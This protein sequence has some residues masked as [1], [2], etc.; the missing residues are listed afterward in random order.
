MNAIVDVARFDQTS[1]LFFTF[2]SKGV[3]DAD[4][5]VTGFTVHEALNEL[6]VIEL[7]LASR[8]ADIDLTKLMD[9]DGVLTVHDRYSEAKRY[10]H[11]IVE[12]AEKGDTGDRFTSYHLT[13]MPTLCRG[14]YITDFRYFQN[15]SVIDIA[16]KVLQEMKIDYQFSCRD[17]YPT[18]EYLCQHRESNL[19]FLDRIL[20]E[21]GIGYHFV[22]AKDGHKMVLFDRSQGSDDCP[23]ATSLEYNPMPSGVVKGSFLSQL[24]WRERMMPTKVTLKE[25]YYKNPQ[26]KFLAPKTAQ[27]MRGLTRDLEVYEYP[28]RHKDDDV[29]K[30][31][32]AHRLD[33]LRS[34]ASCGEA[35]GRCQHLTAGYRFELK[36]HA[37]AAMNRKYFIVSVFHQGTQPT[38][39]EEDAGNGGGTFLTS[40]L[41][42]VKSDDP[43]RPAPRPRALVDGPIMGIITGPAGEEIYC[44]A[45]GRVRAQP[46]YDRLGKFDDKSSCWIRVSQNWAG[47]M[48]GHIAVPRVGQHVIIDYI[49]GDP[50]QPIIVGR[51][52]NANN[53][54]PNKLPDF[55]T[56]MI[57]QSKTHKGEGEN[58]VRLEDEKDQ[59]EFFLQA[60][61]YLN[62]HVKDNETHETKGNRHKRVDGNHSESIGGN[63]DSEV[64]GDHREKITGSHSTSIE[65]SRISKIA[66]SDIIKIIGDKITHI[67][68][69]RFEYIEENLRIQAKGRQHLEVGTTM[70]VNAGDS[71]VIQAGAS[72]SLNVGGNFVKIDGSGVQIEG[73]LIRLNCGGSPAKGTPVAPQD[74]LEPRP[75]S[76]PSAERYSR[77]Y[78]A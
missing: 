7:A 36:E 38:A 13:M 62:I 72:I 5:V 60:Q 16:E 74:A 35:S 58:I 41:S 63:K 54:P 3:P 18:T 9:R 78:Q 48:F 49:D 32:A 12:S 25:H 30:G 71:V 52:Y 29:G 26:H 4:L 23:N 27:D 21:W 61:K 47:T 17:Q 39:L 46:A 6:F 42:F 33:H 11:G 51:A 57:I 64:K 76:G 34:L 73:S 2:D 66:I 1:D 15:E 65:G 28:G 31:F 69:S 19:A 22:H 40:R 56:R 75:Y 8:K 10:F 77:S 44:D 14:R 67:V 37:D 55:K 24:R 59:E 20:A 50:D 70:Y 53:L 45:D 68:R 43:W